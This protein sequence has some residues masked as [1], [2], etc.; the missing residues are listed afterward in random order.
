[1]ERYG[2]NEALNLAG[3][4]ERGALARRGEADAQADAINFARALLE[5]QNAAD[6]EALRKI[7]RDNKWQQSLKIGQE[8]ADIIKR[9][10]L[11]SPA[12]TATVF[13]LCIA[14]LYPSPRPFKLTPD[15]SVIAYRQML[16]GF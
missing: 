4:T 15:K 7:Y 12:A 8:I 13:R 11:D 1:M 14:K 9:V 2:L 10:Q 6:I 16:V 5:Y 3:E